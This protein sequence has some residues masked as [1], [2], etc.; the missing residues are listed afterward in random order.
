[1][2][3]NEIE[4]LV[5]YTFMYAFDRGYAFSDRSYNCEIRPLELML[6]K[7]LYLDW[8]KAAMNNLLRDG[9]LPWELM[10]EQE[11]V[12]DMEMKLCPST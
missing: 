8:R 11:V 2:T 9:T 12:D 7:V 3:R 1:M 6:E 5:R 4:S 10:P